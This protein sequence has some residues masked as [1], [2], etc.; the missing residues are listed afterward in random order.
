M[1]LPCMATFSPSFGAVF[2]ASSVT[3]NLG[4]LYS[5]TLNWVWPDGSPST[6][7]VMR[8]VSRSRG[9]VKLPLKLPYSLVLCRWRSI[10]L[11]LWSTNTT[12]RGWLPSVE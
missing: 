6:R 2:G 8:P 10:S 11:L 5:S 4:R 9:A 12:V 7:I 3:W 1:A